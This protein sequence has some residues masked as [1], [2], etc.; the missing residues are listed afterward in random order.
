MKSATLYF[1]YPCF[2]GLV[3][4]V[5]AWEF[6]EKHKGWNITEFCPAN[7]TVRDTWLSQALKTPC[8]IV[9]FLYHPSAEFWADH[10]QTSMLN[11][12]TKADFLRRK[13]TNCLLFDDQ[14]AS[15]AS[16]LFRYL[17][18]FLSGIPHFEEMVVWA[19]KID[20]AS[21]SSVQEAILGNSP[22]LQINRS[23]LVETTVEYAHFL[24]KELRVHDL[25]Y[26]AR[27]PQV[28]SRQDEVQHQ[29]EAGLKQVENH[30]RVEKNKIVVIETEKRDGEII[31]RYAPYYFVPEARYSITVVRTKEGTSITAMRNPWKEFPSTPLGRIF[32]TFGGG[33]HQRV[34]S[35]VLPPEQSERVGNVVQSLLSQMS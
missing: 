30:I 20:S 31:S 25:S 7:Y 13:A 1:H 2:D 12:E 34:G 18:D 21:Y 29:I 32:E 8:G 11:E 16:L 27:L 19:E 3:S 28:K 9:D 10:H 17:R 6:L 15:C 4:C 35:V 5:L 26:V 24:L 14:A 23:L 33:G 22:A